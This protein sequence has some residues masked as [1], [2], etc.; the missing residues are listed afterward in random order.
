[1]STQAVYSQS[2]PGSE[3]LTRGVLSVSQVEGLARSLTVKVL[4][5]KTWGSGIL[6]QRQGAV[7][8]VLT[9]EHVLRLGDRYRIQT[10]DGQ[11]HEAAI[12]SVGSFQGDDLAVLQFQS[13]QTYQTAT[14][15]NTV[16]ALGET[17]F[18]AGFPAD[19][20]SANLKEFAFTQGQISY[21]LPQPFTLGYQLGYTNDI[22]KGMSGGPVFNQYGQ[23][24]A[25]NGKHK[26][27]LWG[28]TYIFKDGSTPTPEVRQQMDNSS[29]AIPMQTFL[30]QAPQFAR[31]A[32]APPPTSTP[33]RVT[34]VPVEPTTDQAS[35]PATEQ[36]PTPVSETDSA[37]LWG[38]SFDP[39]TPSAEPTAR[40]S[41]FW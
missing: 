29:W 18:A 15:S 22:V 26:Y 35:T 33:S 32:I 27:P 17:T 8:T 5:G 41:S 20:E 4:A 31:V 9:N 6:I 37:S 13:P 14:L 7:Y 39:T 21:L 40:P 36:Q 1:M 28:N 16:P 23:V 3:G 11:I 34:P 25:I 19:P 38:M 24:I 30:Q 10:S 2:N 12:A